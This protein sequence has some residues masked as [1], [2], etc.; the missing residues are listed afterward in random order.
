V[1]TVSSGWWSAAGQLVR[2]APHA[3]AHRVALRV[4]LSILVPLLVLQLLGRPEWSIYAAFGSFPALYG[5]NRVHLSRLRMQ[6]TLGV[7]LVA[8]I[9]AGAAVGVSDA[10]SWLSV[11]LAA[12]LAGVIALLSDAQDWHPPG[13]LFVVFAFT[14]CASLPGDAA[15]VGTAALVGAAAAAFAV[16]VGVVGWV[17]RPMPY[18]PAAE[19]PG[20]GA[21]LRQRRVRM[22]VVRY[23]VAVLVAG[24]LATASGIGHPYWAMVSAVVPM[25][26][27]DLAGQLVR[28]AHRLLG[29]LVGLLLATL[30]LSLPLR[31]LLLVGVVVLL[32]VGAELLV[33]R[34]Y[35]L[36]LIFVTPLALLLGQL[37]VA[38]PPGQ[39]LLDRGVETLVGVAVA[40][41]IT[42]LTRERSAYPALPDAPG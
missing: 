5:R 20:V 1:S 23:V 18:R 11:P 6:L 15:Q 31:G 19:R 16:V 14:A 10:R 22:H 29:T 3:G 38:H 28:G 26:A 35:G 27:P 39:L 40:V 21:L 32:Q 4:G 13:P 8:A 34:N 25:A 42:A 7:V 37:A 12:L 2:V 30:V 36:A 41:T 9:T 33:G 24:S 17:R